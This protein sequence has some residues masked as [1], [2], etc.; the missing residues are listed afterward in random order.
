M[1]SDIENLYITLEENHLNERGGCL[2]SN[3]AEMPENT[4]GNEFENE[5]ENRYSEVRNV[6]P[7]TNANSDR[8]STGSNSSAEIN[9]LSSELNSRLSRE[10]DEMMSCVN[11]QVQ[12]AISVAISSEILP[13]IQST[14]NTGS[15]HVTQIRWNVPSEKPE[16]N[17]ERF[18]NE[19]CKGNSKSEPSCDHPNDGAM[20]T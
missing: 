8:N 15:G 2:N 20:N 6:D 3:R 12:R 14:L 11:T 5:D 10:L 13:Q 4:F 18:C 1:L 7:S 16:V 17:S 9:R 19:K